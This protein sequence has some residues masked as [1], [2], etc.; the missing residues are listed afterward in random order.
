[1]EHEF[2]FI[3][4]NLCL[5]FANSWGGLPADSITQERLTTYP[6]LLDWSLQAGLISEDKA[7][8]LLSNSEKSK[9]EALAT[10]ERALKLRESL[11]EIFLAL[12]RGEQPSE[13]D[14]R[15]LNTELE[16]GMAGA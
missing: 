7:L 16:Q 2:E 12:T 3:G 1:M 13:K 14:F 10:L 15:L 11:R 6:R 4:G 5:D 8:L 9:K